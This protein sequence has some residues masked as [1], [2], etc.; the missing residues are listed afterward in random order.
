MFLISIQHIR[1]HM[2]SLRLRYLQ[3]AALVSNRRAL[4]YVG[5]ALARLGLS[6]VST[7]PLTNPLHKKKGGT[8]MRQTYIS[9]LQIALLQDLLH[10]VLLL[11]RAKLVLERAVRRRVED[12]LVAVPV[13]TLAVVVAL[14]VATTNPRLKRPAD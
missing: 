3:A 1:M 7:L 2:Q 9:L 11:V 12:T 5:V 6:S 4:G 10:H 8:T 14:K 13:D